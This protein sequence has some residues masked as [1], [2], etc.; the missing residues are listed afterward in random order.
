MEYKNSQTLVIENNLPDLNQYSTA[1]RTSWFNGAK[2]K[3]ESTETVRIYALQ[4]KLKPIITSS[5]IEFHW[6]CKNKKK[7]KDNICAAKKF[8]LDGLQEAKILQ[9]DNWEAVSG[10]TDTFYIDKEN[11][12]IIIKL[13]YN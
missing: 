7:D 2:M 8:I 5:F 4:Q 11:P 1:C 13:L 12:R 6:Y 10:F 3:R 9:Q